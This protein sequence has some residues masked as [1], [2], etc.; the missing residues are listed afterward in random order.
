MA[1]LL[2]AAADLLD[3]ANRPSSE[4]GMLD[5][6]KSSINKAIR[7]SNR[8]HPFKYA[9]RAARITYPGE[10]FMVDLNSVCD[11]RIIGLNTV[12]IVSSGGYAGF[13]IKVTSYEELQAQRRRAFDNSP[14]DVV[15][16]HV[17]EATSATESHSGFLLGTSIGLFPRPGTSAV[18]LLV[19][20]NSLLPELTADGDTNFILEYGYDFI[21]TKALQKFNLYLKADRRVEVTNEQIQNEWESFKAWDRSVISSHA[22]SV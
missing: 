11:G 9:E 13:P 18:E 5:R 10:A 19:T 14:S 16:D 7:W 22:L 8:S 3:W 17:R 20:Y 2:T 1:T 6:A 21:L 4:T 12:Q 15:T